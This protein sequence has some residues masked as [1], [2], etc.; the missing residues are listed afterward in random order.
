MPVDSRDYFYD[1]NCRRLISPTTATRARRAGSTSRSRRITWPDAAEELAEKVPTSAPTPYPRDD[2]QPP[3]VVGPQ[4]AARAASST[5]GT[6]AAAAGCYTI[7]CGDV[8]LEEG[9]SPFIDEKGESICKYLMFSADV[10]HDNDRYGFYRDWKGAQDE[11]NQRRSKALHLL[12]TRRA[13]ARARRRRRHRADPARA[14]AAR[15]HRREKQGL[16]V[17]SWT[18]TRSHGR[19]Q[20]QHGDARRG[21]SR[22]RPVRAQ[23]RR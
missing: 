7:Y 20:G 1:P 11:I 13:I 3:Q 19:R 10:D 21:E 6:S 14:G 23:P 2:D 18:I 17:H 16:R 4:R 8:I 22:D 12:N 15:W 5:T 9:E